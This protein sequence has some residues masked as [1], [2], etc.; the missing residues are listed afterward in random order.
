M[1]IRRR[2]K[3]WGTNMCQFGRGGRG[4]RSGTQ[5]II[6]RVFSVGFRPYSRDVQPPRLPPPTKTLRSPFVSSGLGLS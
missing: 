5:D 1:W 3:S 2:C 4:G 6:P